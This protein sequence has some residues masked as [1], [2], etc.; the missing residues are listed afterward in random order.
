MD[1][2][3]HQSHTVPVRATREPRPAQGDGEDRTTLGVAHVRDGFEAAEVIFG[4]PH[5]PRGGEARSLPLSQGGDN[6][7]VRVEL[8]DIK[9]SGGRSAQAGA[10]GT[11]F[12]AAF[13]MTGANVASC[14]TP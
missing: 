9:C 11:V 6:V 3:R 13:T 12:E 5:R 8:I 10:L 2:Q 1:P 14:S 4:G 7:K